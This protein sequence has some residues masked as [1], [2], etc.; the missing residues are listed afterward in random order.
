MWAD[1]DI[2]L[3]HVEDAFFEGVH[4]GIGVIAQRAVEFVGEFGDARYPIADHLNGLLILR[5]RIEPVDQSNLNYRKFEK[6]E[7][8]KH[9]KEK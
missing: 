7:K 9:L 4:E 1:L 2:D 5:A 8:K 6:I 3:L